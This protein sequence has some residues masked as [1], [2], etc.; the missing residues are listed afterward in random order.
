METLERCVAALGK[1]PE[2]VARS[3]MADVPASS[4]SDDASGKCRIK[5]NIGGSGKIYHVPGTAA[6][7][8]TK[9]D[10]VKGERWFCSED[11]ARA[12][13]WRAPKG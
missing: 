13:G 12:A 10:A 5:G 3:P 7:E 2:A 9:I 4:A 8:K 11:E 6:Y 1:R